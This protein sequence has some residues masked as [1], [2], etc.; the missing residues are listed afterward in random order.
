MILAARAIGKQARLSLDVG[1]QMRQSPLYRNIRAD[2]LQASPLRSPT[3]AT[4]PVRAGGLGQ[5][6][7][8]H[9]GACG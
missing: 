3:P 8:D 5:R 2:D 7:A 6:R 9:A 1:G 4:A